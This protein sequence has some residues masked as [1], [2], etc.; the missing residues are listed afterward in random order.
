[1]NL[2]DPTWDPFIRTRSIVS[3]GEREIR[4]PQNYFTGLSQMV[5]NNFLKTKMKP[6]NKVRI[7]N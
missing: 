7:L 4:D 2:H 3:T 1:M 5:K 6:K